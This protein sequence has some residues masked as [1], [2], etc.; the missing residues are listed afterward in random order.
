MHVTSRFTTSLL[1]QHHTHSSQA[2]PHMTSRPQTCLQ[3]PRSHLC[4]FKLQQPKPKVHSPATWS[5]Q[6]RRSGHED[7]H[8]VAA[9]KKFAILARHTPPT[10]ERCK[11]R[12]A[13]RRLQHG[14]ARRAPQ[15]AMCCA[16]ATLPRPVRNLALPLRPRSTPAQAPRH[17]A[18]DAGAVRSVRRAAGS[19]DLAAELAVLYF[20]AV[21]GAAVASAA[22]S[23]AIAA[24][25]VAA[26]SLCRSGA[27]VGAE[28]RSAIARSP[29]AA[30]ASLAAAA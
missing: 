2:L 23:A 4:C 9:A 24:A 11:R 17:D 29:A 14:R 5:A 20:R 1:L 19:Q 15:P 12:A 30:S 8:A 16:C 21:A 7:T 22:L 6:S 25:C 10:T 13:S 26:S 18:R 27:C 3:M 28:R